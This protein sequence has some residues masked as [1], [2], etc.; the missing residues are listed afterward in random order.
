MTAEKKREDQLKA[1]HSIEE[2]LNKLSLA[3][4]AIDDQKKEEKLAVIR[5]HKEE[6]ERKLVLLKHE[7]EK[8]E[9][10]QVS[11]LLQ[12]N[13]T[14]CR[15]YRN[16]WQARLAYI[17]EQASS[18]IP[19]DVIDPVVRTILTE[20]GL[21]HL[22]PTFAQHRVDAVVLRILTADDLT[23]MGI[24]SIGDQKKILSMAASLFGVAEP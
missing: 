15:N 8:K 6:L 18:A 19:V 7:N 17:T 24:T 10:H 2:E 22:A 11:L 1:I 4:V 20:A 21:L 13:E 9:Q 16:Y 3:A 14:D 23:K 5:Q 12:L